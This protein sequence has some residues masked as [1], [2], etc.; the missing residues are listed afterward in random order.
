[1]KVLVNRSECAKSSSALV[2]ATP[3][4]WHT[5]PHSHKREDDSRNGGEPLAQP[6][7]AAVETWMNSRVPTA[8]SSPQR[9]AQID[10]IG[11]IRVRNRSAVGMSGRELVAGLL[12]L[13]TSVRVSRLRVGS[14]TN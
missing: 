13:Q 3:R 7:H 11:Q 5:P 2:R 12:T 10:R 6:V 14:P 8:S 1:M 9:L 4:S